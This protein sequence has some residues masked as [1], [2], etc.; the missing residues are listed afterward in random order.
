MW[1]LVCLIILRNRQRMKYSET[2]S[3]LLLSSIVFSA[4]CAPSGQSVSPSAIDITPTPS[5]T[6]EASL[7]PFAPTATPLQVLVPPPDTTPTST[8]DAGGAAVLLAAGDRNYAQDNI[9]GAL[10]DYSLAIRADPAYALA[11]A[12]R[13]QAYL[14][15]GDIES[16]M[17]DFE[18][19]LAIDEFLVEAHVGRARAL[20]IQEDFEGALTALARAIEID[21]DYADAYLERGKLYRDIFGATER[22]E[23]ALADF[24][25]FITL[26]PESPDGYVERGELYLIAEQFELAL[27]DLNVAI[28]ID[29]SLARALLLRGQCHLALDQIEPAIA[30]FEL[31]R[32]LGIDSRRLDTGLGTSYVRAARYQEAL[33]VLTVA[34]SEN[35]ADMEIRYLRG[36]ASLLNGDSIG[37]KQDMDLILASEPN[38]IEALAVR[39]SA[40]LT[41]RRWQEAIIDFETTYGLDNDYVDAMYG[42]AQARI[43]LGDFDGALTAIERYLAEAPTSA[44]NYAAA[45]ALRDL[46]VGALT[47]PTPPP[48]PQ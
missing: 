11:Y 10:N 15:F 16:A 13:G 30:D 25:R 22:R 23:Q 47:E 20:V 38:N 29:P 45:S 40:L 1:T 48:S 34:L 24:E 9:V 4:G 2:L 7:T 36:L 12:R 33:N 18:D 42:I 14:D 17:R 35:P 37:A 8:Y 28:A 41:L 39:G 21:Q 31:A 6:M 32:S 26:V 5:T 46:L 44:R 19:S 3:L 43:G 27:V